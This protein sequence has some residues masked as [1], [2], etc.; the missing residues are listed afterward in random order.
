MRLATRTA[1]LGALLVLAAVAQPATASATGEPIARWTCAA[2]GLNCDP[3]TVHCTSPA[4][5]VA[6]GVA[7]TF[8]GRP[9]SDDRAGAAPG[10]VVAWS[11]TFGDGATA[12][13]AQVSHAFAQAG[14]Y[15]VTLLATD[16]SGKA[17][18]KTLNIVVAGATPPPSGY[19]ARILATPGLLSF[20]RLGEPSGTAAADSKGSRTGTY[21]GGVTQGAAGALSGDLN[22][23]AAFDG[24]ND[25][26]RLPALP[27]AVNFTV[28]GW[29]RLASGAPANNTLFGSAATVRLVGRPSGFYADVVIGGV[30]YAMLG[31]GA[32]NSGV[33]VHWALV[34]AGA[35]LS[36][37]RNGVKVVTRTGLPAATAA[38]LSGSIGRSS[39]AF[40]AK[41]SIDEVAVYGSALG[42][43]EV[44]AHYASR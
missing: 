28:E 8:D 24:V 23:A 10:T 37:Y 11:W 26:V 17:D 9:S 5:K 14:T 36:L 20:W 6:P 41:G 22:A 15:P 4:G 39:S 27:S 7:V 16:D 35:T 38:G 42:A 12:T 29:Q 40:P 3:C 43:A 32:S 30:R 33:W 25:E 2:P 31:T 1:L 21:L 18:A 44:Q 34:R 13:G 19:A